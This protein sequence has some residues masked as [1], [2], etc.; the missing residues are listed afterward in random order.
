MKRWEGVSQTSFIGE[1]WN[2]SERSLL[3][4]ASVEAMYPKK[5]FIFVQDSALLNRANQVQNVLKQKSTLTGLQNCLIATLYITTFGT[6]FK[7]KYTMF[8]IVT[9]L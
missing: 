1:K 2:Q 4:E 9:L 5:D 8:A 7:R 6:T 3:L